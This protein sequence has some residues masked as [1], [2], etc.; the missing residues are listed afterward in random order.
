MRTARPFGRIVRGLV[1]RPLARETLRSLLTVGGIAVGVAVIVA[2]QLSN[3]SAIRSFADSVE[4]VAGRAN[5]QISPAAGSLDESLLLALRPLWEQ[6]GRFAPVIDVEVLLDP[7]GVPARILGVDL[8]SDLHFRDY[9]WARIATSDEQIATIDEAAAPSIPQLLALFEPGAAIL[10]ERFSRDHSIPIGSELTIVF[11]DRRAELLVRGI[12]HPR[13]PATAFNGSLVVLDVATA[14]RA[15]GM[16]GR[17]TRV[18]LMLPEPLAPELRRQIEAAL[19]DGAL[20]ERPSRRNERVDRML[21]AFRVNLFALAAVA[22]L[23]G[24]FLV[25]NTVLISVLRRRRDIG[26][27]RTLG[28]S[29]KQILAAFLAEGAVLGIAGSIA[30]VALGWILA[31]GAAD[32]V[33]RTVNQL[34]LTSAPAPIELTPGLVATGFA[35]GLAV[36]LAASLQ[37]AWEASRVPPSAMIRPG[38]YQRLSR[39]RTRLLAASALAAFALA[40]ALSRPGPVGGL[41]VWG[42]VSVTLVIAGFSMLAPLALETAARTLRRPFAKLFGVSGR[43]AA[44]SVPASLRRTAVATAA[45]TMAIAMMASVAIMI[46]SFRETVDAWVGQTVQSDLWVR[47]AVG[48][49][50]SDVATL[51]PE[52]A[53][54]LR[55]MPEVAAVDRFR[56]TEVIW[57]DSLITVGSGELE[58]AIDWGSIPMVRPGDHREALRSAIE[59]KGVLVSESLALK[60][61][62]EP[63][64]ALELPTPA[65]TR[66]F[67][68]TGIYR[69]YSNDRGVVV[70]DRRV[71]LE[72]FGDPGSNTIALFLA[73]GVDPERARRVIEERIAARYRAFVMTNA[74]VRREVLRIFDQTFLITWALLGVALAVAVLGIVNTLTALILERKRELALLRILGM[75]PRQVA[76]MI[77]LEASVLGAASVVLGLACGWIVSWILIFVINRQSF[78]WTIELA[79]PVAILVLSVGLTFAATVAA[80]LIPARLVRAIDLAREIETE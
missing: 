45:L 51:P 29:A 47:P 23:V 63:G 14:Q 78:G 34:Y 33:G 54:E 73:E 22:L 44:A 57:R 65:G 2:I 10:P 36:S 31:R 41:P 16:E 64:D 24:V 48:L 32:L 76:S 53:E 39:A 52:L 37:P 59:R 6:G 50:N 66:S 17:L 4:A 58:V 8:M 70:M 19:P 80:G 28:V 30:G 49:T 35:V 77:V 40:W 3:R 13:G 5:F 46:G 72:T 7:S 42:Y 61:D 55:A 20:L 9:E 68:V 71:W 26:V 62:V 38:L 25:Y 67:P 75:D 11:R 21:R 79:P 60:H 56:G 18:D 74:T 43:L 15:L 1:L 69:D 27:F 12:L